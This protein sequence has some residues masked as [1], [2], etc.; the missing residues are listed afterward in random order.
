MTSKWTRLARGEPC[1]VRLPEVC[2][3]PQTVVFAHLRLIGISG[4]GLKAPDIIGCPACYA[5]HDEIDRRTSH[6]SRDVAQ[7]AHYEGAARWLYQL[8]KRG[9]LKL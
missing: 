5:C 3:D 1:Y 6:Y 4:A 8:I 2:G 7:M 9:A